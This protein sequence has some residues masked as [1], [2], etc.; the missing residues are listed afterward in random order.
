LPVLNIRPVIPQIHTET[1]LVYHNYISS[2]YKK[3]SSDRAVNT[4][5]LGYRKQSGIGLFGDTHKHIW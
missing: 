2:L 5:C 3:F 1:L 4:L